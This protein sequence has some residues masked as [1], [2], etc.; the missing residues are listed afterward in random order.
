MVG[1]ELEEYAAYI[2]PKL[3]EP[4]QPGAVFAKLALAA[5]ADLRGTIAFWNDERFSKY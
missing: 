1:E 2:M 4:H 5:S 3:V